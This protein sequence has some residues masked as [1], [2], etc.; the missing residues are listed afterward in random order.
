MCRVRVK[1]PLAA[2]VTPTRR[3]SSVSRLA[4]AVS[5]RAKGGYW[6]FVA[7]GSA[8]R[9]TIAA[10][11][12]LSFAL[13]LSLSHTDTLVPGC[14]VCQ[15]IPSLVSLCRAVYICLA[16]GAEQEGDCKYSTHTHKKKQGGKGKGTSHRA[17]SLLHNGGSKRQQKAP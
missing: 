17:V 15:S 14:C 16:G 7:V 10:A 8:R 12:R 4:F 9:F 11:L 2:L 6:L 1:Q 13:S 3:C 5:L